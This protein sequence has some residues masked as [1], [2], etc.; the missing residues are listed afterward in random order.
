MGTVDPREDPEL[1][2]IALGNRDGDGLQIGGAPGRDRAAAA[3]TAGG[4]GRCGGD[5]PDGGLDLQRERAFLGDP[6]GAAGV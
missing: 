1:F 4:R 3:R 2:D 6:D 5:P